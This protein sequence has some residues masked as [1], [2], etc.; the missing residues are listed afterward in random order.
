M[1]TILVV[2]DETD[3][4]RLVAESLRRINHEVMVA[5][6]GRDGLQLLARAKFDVVVCDLFMPDMDGIE[7]LK[8][9]RTTQPDLPVITMTGGF[10]GSTYPFTKVVELLGADHVLEKPFP[11]AQ[12]HSVIA[13]FTERPRPA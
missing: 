6:N 7:M 12:L 13:K 8:Q 9:L 10:M 5:S 2:D 1:A 4:A 11:L 3:F